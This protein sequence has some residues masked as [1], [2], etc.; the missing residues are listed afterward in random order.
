MP[1]RGTVPVTPTTAGCFLDSPHVA[2]TPNLQ[3]N[4]AECHYYPVFAGFL[5]I[6]IRAAQVS[7]AAFFLKTISLEQF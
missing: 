7:T 1:S 2:K 4:T 6:I 5:S 3:S